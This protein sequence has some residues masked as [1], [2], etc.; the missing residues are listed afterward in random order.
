M[1]E[2]QTN[3]DPFPSIK[4][5]KG[6]LNHHRYIHIYI[7][8]YVVFMYID[9]VYILYLL[10]IIRLKYVSTCYQVVWVQQ[11]NMGDPKIRDN[12]DEFTHEKLLEDI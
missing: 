11:F 10:Y 2:F 9:T 6:I 8:I 4:D 3:S 5:N 7:C 1:F 12:S